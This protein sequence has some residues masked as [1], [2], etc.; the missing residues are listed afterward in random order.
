MDDDLQLVQ[1]MLEGDERAF[2]R[3]A[4]DYIPALYRFVSRR[5]GGDRELAREIVQTTICKVM[6]KLGSFRGESTLVTWL[7][8]CCRNEIAG[9]FRRK[10]RPY[11]EVDL[12]LD[13]MPAAGGPEHR[14]L[15]REKARLVHEALDTVPPRYGKALEWK[16]LEKV[17]VREIA[18]RLG[19]G[20]KAAESLLTRARVA[21]RKQYELLVAGARAETG[22]RRAPSGSIDATQGV[23]EWS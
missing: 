9:H 10:A 13:D 14:V 16:Y 8:A 21:F 22:D 19:V 17:S 7:C 20:P 1:R 5:L 4:D 12:E 18:E 11:R 3:F 6:G 23:T 15:Q 2:E